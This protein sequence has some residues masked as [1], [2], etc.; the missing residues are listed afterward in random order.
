MEYDVQQRDMLYADPQHDI[1]SLDHACVTLCI[2]RSGGNRIHQTPSTTGR[3]RELDDDSDEGDHGA[4]MGSAKRQRNSHHCFRCGYL[5][6]LAADCK[7]DTTIAGKPGATVASN[8]RFKHA[9]RAHTGKEFCFKFASHSSCPVGNCSRVHR[10]SIC[11]D[12]THGALSCPHAE[13]QNDDGF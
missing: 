2:H 6:H 9:L 12:K 11:H 10:C 3:K 1:S 7:R 5:G 8:S 4:D 13:S